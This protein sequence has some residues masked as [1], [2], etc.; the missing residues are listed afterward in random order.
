MYAAL[1]VGCVY[2][3]CLT[4]RQARLT[5]AVAALSSTPED[6]RADLSRCGHAAF[7]YLASALYHHMDERVRLGAGQVLLS[8]LVTGLREQVQRHPADAPDAASTAAIA[9]AKLVAK[10]MA[11]GNAVEGMG[12]SVLTP[13]LAYLDERTAGALDWQKRMRKRVGT[14]NVSA[15]LRDEAPE[16]R[17]VAAAVL[18]VIGPS[19]ALDTQ[20]IELCRKLERILAGTPKEDGAGLAKCKDQLMTIGRFGLP[21]L[22]GIVASSTTAY[23]TRLFLARVA[24]SIVDVEF[25]RNVRAKVTSLLGQRASALLVLTLAK[26]QGDLRQELMAVLTSSPK[27][28]DADIEQLVG[29]FTSGGTSDWPERVVQGIAGLEKD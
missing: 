14:D 9:R 17:E 2:L 28:S 12:L 19:S 20:R 26:A 25:S 11:Q 27:V 18:D 3:A 8:G 29:R 22:V 23:E 1:L 4:T 6:S 13:L 15:A 16:V 21:A 10:A 7:E 5:E 24:G